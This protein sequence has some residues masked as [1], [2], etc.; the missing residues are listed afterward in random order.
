[1]LKELKKRLDRRRAI[2]DRS[3]KAGVR[4]VIAWIGTV[5]RFLMKYGWAI[6]AMVI[7]LVL[8]KLPLPEPILIG[9]KW[10]MIISC[11]GLW[12]K[13]LIGYITED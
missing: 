9:I 11:I 6:V 4:A 13:Y 2:F 7:G 1:M 3:V 5:L 10:C 12:I 8:I